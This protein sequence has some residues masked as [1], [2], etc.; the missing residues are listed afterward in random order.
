[1]EFFEVLETTWA[2]RRFTDEPV[3]DADVRRCLGAATRAPS[4]GNIQPWQFVVVRDADARRKIGAIYKRAY[5]RYEKALDAVRQPYKREADE[6]NFLRIQRSARHLA[7]HFAEVPVHVLFLMPNID[8]TLTDEAGPLDIGTAH[9]SVFPAVQNFMLAARAI[10]LGTTLTT[11]CRI[12]QDEVR[13]LCAIPEHYE[14]VALVPLGHPAM[15]FG[16][17]RRRPIET[18]THWD[19]FGDRKK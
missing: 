18:V 7:D 9:A 12:Y 16:R 3:S 15:K 13:E 10:G 5:E 17:G 1:M 11:A 4:G 19:R 14:V 8:M 2:V 6:K